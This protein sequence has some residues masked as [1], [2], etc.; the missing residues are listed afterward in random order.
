VS[1]LAGDAALVTGAGSGIGRAIALA[2]AAAGA[3]TALVGRDAAK[4]E[5][6]RER[7]AAR[8]GESAAFA[9]DVTSEADVERAVSGA[10]A[11]FGGLSIVVNDA[12]KGASAPVSKTTLALWNEL[13]AVNLTGAFLVTRAA[14][15]HLVA[16]GRGRV[17][18]VA[19][20]AG[21]RGYPYVAAYCA[22]KHGLV[23][24]TR[25]LAVE[26]APK[27]VTVNA[28]CPGYVDTD[29]TRETIR[30][31]AEKT[32]RTPEAARA[33]L[34]AMSPQKRLFTP[35]EVAAAALFLLGPLSRGVSGQAIPVDG[36]ET[37][38]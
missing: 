17:V 9:A 26:L 15:P 11:R 6:T 12:G 5:A 32:G 24:L 35:E 34:E 13:L 2:L 23:G 4:L 8:G 36:G 25:A 16:S 38:G 1:A 37:A 10:A 28:V 18:N 20:V 3:R 19:S 29:M 22:A 33:A 21:L 14:L 7:I 30:N 27:N 31:V